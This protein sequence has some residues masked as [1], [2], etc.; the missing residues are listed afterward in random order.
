MQKEGAGL[1]LAATDISNHLAC[2]HLTQ[3]DRAVAEGRR[4]APSWSDPSLA[5]LQERGFEHERAFI[6][7]LRSEDLRVVEPQQE[8]GKLSME[9]TLQAMRDGADVIVQAELRKGQLLG[10]ADVL[11]RVPRPSA[12]GDWSYEVADTKLSQETRAGTVL[13]LCLYSELVSEAQGLSPEWMHVVKPGPGFPRESFRFDDYGAYYRLVRRGLEE[14][15]A[16]P[17]SRATYPDPVEHCRIC[18]W[19]KECDQRRHDDDKLCLVAGIRPLHIGELERQGIRT[20]TQYAEEP[21]PLRQ[22]PERGSRVAFARAHGQARVQLD[23]RRAGQPRYE[24]L[25]PEPGLGFHRLPE[26]DTGDVF[27]D[28]E[29]DPF[30]GDDGMEYLF[31]IAYGHPTLQYRA[32][33][34]LNPEEERRGIEDLIDF[35]MDQ[36]QSNPGMHVYHFSP[37]EPGAVKRLIGRHGT[38]EAELDRLLRAERFIDLLAVTRHG[39]RA[40]VESYSLKELEKFHGFSRALEL[41]AASA[42]LRRI[43]RALELARAAEITLEEK[44][45]VEVYNRDDCLST[46]SLRDWLEERRAELEGRG[47][48][49]ARPENRSGDASEALEE[50]AAD[51][52]QIYDQLINGLP[53]DRSAWGPMER[54][55][56]LLAHQVDYFRREEKCYWW[57]YFRIHGLDHEDLLEERKAVSGLRFIG[58]VGGS[59]KYPV[60]RYSFPEQEVD[61]GEGKNLEEI[62]TKTR[63]GTVYAI[64]PAKHTIDIAKTGRTTDLHP[65]AVMIEDLVRPGSVEKSFLELARSVARN[66]VSGAGPFQAGR[67]LLMARPPR[68]EREVKG[69]LRR[70]GEEIVEAAVRLARSLDNGILPIQGPPGSGKTFT[71]GRMIVALAREGKRIGVTAVSHKVIQKLLT[72]ALH[73]AAL[74]GFPLQAMRK[75]RTGDGETIEGV[76][77]T[78]DNARL[79]LGLQQGVVVGGTAWLWSQ[80]DMKGSLDYL[81]VDEA[82]QISLAQAL[83]T[84]P[85]ARNLVLLGDPQQLEQ[86]QKGAHPE[87][88]EVAA[89]VH[90]LADRKTIA[91]DAGLF[92]DETWRLHPR[93]C[94]FTSELFYENRLA[95]RAGLEKQAI[96]GS[97]RFAGSGLFY[98][99]VEHTGNQNSSAEE[100]DVIAGIVADL[101]QDG[102]SWTNKEGVSQPLG[103]S[104][105]LVVAPYNAQVAALARRLGG[106][107]RVGTV[108]KFQGQEAPVVIYTMTSSSA[109][110]APRGMSFLYSPNRLN[111]ATSRARCTCILVASP[112][113]LEPETHSP[114][115]MR[116][117]NALCRYREMATEVAIEPLP[118]LSVGDV[119]PH[120]PD[121]DARGELHGP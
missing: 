40:S 27:F 98:V 115:Q 65:A 102:V 109:E 16:A 99:P 97:T 58:P 31:G 32:L 12:L 47:T 88:A 43:D 30:A 7:Q 33:W 111:V 114:D 107:A 35:I 104:D 10:R 63:V 49:V 62:G 79:L 80:E 26:P 78:K 82:G 96:T 39:V 61:P 36:W 81:F 87:G 90:V 4:A 75:D 2:R 101:S 116:W 60:H 22:R 77:V 11:L 120:E 37:Y 55:R 103:P 1:R 67:D 70:T 92:L 100:V 66:G 46:A 3:L 118:R 59:A 106:A 25:A 69:S 108:D 38:R 76:L 53:E 64:D 18:R 74:E 21:K 72:E 57:E 13:Q 28:I 14:A 95:S 29:S 56:W 91:D 23:G 110:D 34:A 89:L 9:Q 20:L 45:A 73:A 52:Q 94:S 15:V 41:P 8:G 93:I 17:P 71:G 6:R 48:P 24:L 19:W 85:S 83:A 68:L 44:A 117:A 105:I 54:A 121:A 112:R 51:V 42:A 86:P 84:A 50:R 113:L 119:E 5:L